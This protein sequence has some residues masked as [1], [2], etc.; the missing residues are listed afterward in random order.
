MSKWREGGTVP[1]R[2][3]AGGALAGAVPSF[4]MPAC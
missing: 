2:G 1:G 4:A 3:G